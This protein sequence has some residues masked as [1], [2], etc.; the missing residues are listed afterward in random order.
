M[1]PRL[2]FLVSSHLIMQR[3]AVGVHVPKGTEC[4][5]TTVK[6]C[7]SLVSQMQFRRAPRG[8]REGG[9]RCDSNFNKNA[10]PLGR[11]TRVQ[12]RS[13]VQTFPSQRTGRS[14]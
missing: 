3:A 14:D 6:R 9:K 13:A 10:G 5:Q 1:C 2:H 8:S 7:R 12:N 4:P 11:L